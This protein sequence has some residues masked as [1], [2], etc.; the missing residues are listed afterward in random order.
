MT[1]WEQHHVIVLG[2]NICETASDIFKSPIFHRILASF[3]EDL[4]QHQAPELEAIKPFLRT[5]AGKQGSGAGASNLWDKEAL[6]DLLL[7]LTEYRP[8]EIS[9]RYPA[10]NPALARKTML[11]DFVEKLY[12]YWRKYARFLIVDDGCHQA[13]ETASDHHKFIELNER[14]TNLVLEIYRKIGANLMEK[15][16]RVYRQLPCG[17]GAGI[18]ADKIAWDIPGEEYRQLQAIPFIQ[19]VVIEPPLVYYPKRNYRKGMFMPVSHNPL[20]HS[21]LEA[22]DWLCYPAKVGDLLTFIYFHKR[23]LPLGL[24]LAN[25]FELAEPAEIQGRRPEAMLIFGVEPELLGK[26]QTV[27]YEDRQAGIVLGLIGRT[28]DV[29]YFGYFKKMVLTLHN[30][31][32]IEHGYLPVHGAMARIVLR[33]GA[34]ANVVLVG[35]SGAGKSESLEAFRVLATDYMRRLTVI[36][37]DMGSLRI[38]P[39]GEV[40]GIGTEI[41]AFVRLDDLAPGF[42]YA[43]IDRS[44]F[45]NPH[46][47]NARLVIPIT[48][49]QEVTRGYPVD[50]F[51]YA[52]NYEPVDNKHPHIELFN[53]VDTALEVFSE[54][55]RLSKGTTDEEGL[56]HTYFANPFGAPQKRDQHDALARQYFSQMLARGVKIGQLRTQLGL[57]GYEIKGPEAAAKALF[58]FI[59]YGG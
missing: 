3:I 45:M 21:Q 53:D 17:A 40:V 57:H 37:D 15:L 28:D 29:D 50:L 43:E 16:P 6:A 44:I 49:Y 18:L 56:V 58:E 41:G 35:D 38:T 8:D 2:P 51:L 7:L 11:Y 39:E 4:E 24:S 12:N 25:L 19:L 9:K 42:P 1:E 22:R 46:K 36:F 59:T 10:F 13:G 31:I 47:K 23:Y 20:K 33:T 30:L 34:S 5:P 32:A 52:N 27:Y 54:G 14:F 55:A 26:R 48:N